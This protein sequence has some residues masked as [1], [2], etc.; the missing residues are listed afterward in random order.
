MSSR[1]DSVIRIVG[2]TMMG[3][4][5]TKLRAGFEALSGCDGKTYRHFRS[6]CGGPVGSSS[7]QFSPSTV[8]KKAESIGFARFE[9]AVGA[10]PISPPLRPA[11]HN[12]VP[13]VVSDA[14]PS[15]HPSLNDVRHLVVPEGMTLDLPGIY[16]WKIEGG[17]VYVGRYTNKSRI[18][19]EYENNIR[20]L[21]SGEPY[22]RQKPTGFRRIHRALADA[23]R[24]HRRIE[25]HILQNCLPHELDH[26]ERSW[27]A[28]I[29]R[30]GLDG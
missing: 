30:G 27:I 26:Q 12:D 6:L 21:L 3:A 24:H 20:R 5:G 9:D 10:R 23:V 18:L 16:A 28:A 14:A 13:R 25:L 19:R 1:L 11:L 17:A 2:S 29:G 4:K 7:R 15:V 8:W 22:R